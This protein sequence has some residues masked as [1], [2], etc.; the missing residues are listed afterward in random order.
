MSQ[1][2]VN[3]LILQVDSL[4]SCFVV[5]SPMRP[6]R[7]AHNSP[8]RRPPAVAS[9]RAGFGSFVA[10]LRRWTARVAVCYTGG[11]ARV[12]RVWLSEARPW[13]EKLPRKN[14]PGTRPRKRRGR[15]RR[16]SGKPPRRL[17]WRRRKNAAVVA[18]RATR[19]SW[20]RRFARG[21]RRAN[22]CPRRA[23][24]LA[25]RVSRWSVGRKNTPISA[26]YM[27]V[28]AKPKPTHVLNLP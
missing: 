15:R 18:R 12:V 14:R 27:L 13:R 5:M 19:R 17:T 4:D 23:R 2:G 7:G 24:S 6:M 1:T 10:R 22:W 26:R 21:S 16:R 8:R 25:S 9:L 20:P 28:R 11:V 3:V